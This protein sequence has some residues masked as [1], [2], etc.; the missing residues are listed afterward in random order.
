MNEKKEP[1][2]QAATKPTDIKKKEKEMTS[3][4]DTRPTK[5]TST[6]RKI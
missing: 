5:P 3:K 2:P 6:N 4:I 1:F